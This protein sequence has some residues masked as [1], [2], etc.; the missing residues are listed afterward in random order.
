MSVFASSSRPAG[1]DASF[2]LSRSPPL[3]AAPEGAD[4]GEEGA[5]T[6][7]DGAYSG[8]FGVCCFAGEPPPPPLSLGAKTGEPGT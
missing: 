3:A 6:G 2:R 5:Y 7:E 4:T 8:D 1:A